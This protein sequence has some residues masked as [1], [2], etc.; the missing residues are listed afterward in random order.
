MPIKELKNIFHCQLNIFVLLGFLA[1]L[2]SNWINT[3]QKVQYNTNLI[4]QRDR[5]IYR[6]NDVNLKW[7]LLMKWNE[8]CWRGLRELK[9]WQFI[10]DLQVCFWFAKQFDKI[11]S[12]LSVALFAGLFWTYSKQLIT[13]HDINILAYRVPL[14]MA[15]KKLTQEDGK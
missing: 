1:F 11:A 6:T 12:R 2:G 7:K 5:F 13:F 9:K 15:N 4:N 3:W 14:I 8:K 10:F